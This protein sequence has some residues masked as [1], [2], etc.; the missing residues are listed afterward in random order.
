MNIE[1]NVIFLPRVADTHEMAK[2]Y[3]STKMLVCASTVEGNPR[4][5]IEAMACGVPVIS[6]PVG[7]M[8]EV[9]ENG[10]NGFLVDWKAEDIADKIHCLLDDSILYDKMA[11]AGRQSVQIF[12]AEAIIRD[13]ALGYHEIVTSEIVPN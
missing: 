4:V 13:Y 1:K 11:E 10:E 2:L 7:I 9:I 12:E 5:T 6:T 8:P 3:N